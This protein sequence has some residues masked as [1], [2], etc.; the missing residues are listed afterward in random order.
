ML[1]Y[2][3]SGAAGPGPA[4]FKVGLRFGEYYGFSGMI[5]CQ[6]FLKNDP[7]FP[8]FYG[9][10]GQT[11]FF[12]A[13]LLSGGTVHEKNRF[14]TAR[15]QRNRQ[16]IFPIRVCVH[17]AKLCAANRQRAGD[18]KRRRKRQYEP[19]IRRYAGTVCKNALTTVVY[20]RGRD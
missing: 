19:H 11:A 6:K 4:V 5:N 13:L 1:A 20:Q 8:F 15:N 12:D 14:I 10:R 17:H 16:L 3:R 18:H 7:G 2:R 9:Q